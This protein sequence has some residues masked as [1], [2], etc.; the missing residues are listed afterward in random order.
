MLVGLVPWVGWVGLLVS[1]LVGWMVRWLAG[2]LLGWW[3]C[4][5][6][7]RSVGWLLALWLGACLVVGWVVG[8]VYDFLIKR[9]I[10]KYPDTFVYVDNIAIIVK[11]YSE[12]EQLLTVL[13]AWGFRLGSSSIP[14]KW[15]CT[16][17]TDHGPR[18]LP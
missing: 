8:I 13:S 16:S 11:D 3:V 5:V 15:K 12:L 4:L 1:G 9:L 6:V 18:A 14:T 10:G 2:W 7:W 17:S